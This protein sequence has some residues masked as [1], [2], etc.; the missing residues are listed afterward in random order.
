MQ[1]APSAPLSADA[2][3]F[4]RLVASPG[5]NA[6]Q[7]I[8]QAL[9]RLDAQLRSDLK[10]CRADAAPSADFQW[11]R[12][13]SVPMQGPR[14]LSFLAHDYWNCGGA[15]DDFSILGLV[16]DLSTGS[17][18]NWAR[19]LPASMVQ[20]TAID[21]AGDGTSIGVLSSRVFQDLY[22]K[23]ENSDPK[24]PLDPE[25]RDVLSD[26]GLKFT[27]WPDAEGDGIAI[28][29]QGLPHVVAACGA[30]AI[31]IPTT[32]LRRLGV[33]PALLDAIDTAHAQGWYSHKP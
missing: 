9:G 14:Y 7:R 24:N 18:V 29:T 25:C 32:T 10:D 19:L 16:Y 8:N 28:Q 15:H 17:P 22:L 6:A 4:P 23:A 31:V 12:T 13:I 5:D 1:L 3:A 27:I 20:G 11:S 21:T 33:Q 30:D 2:V 26:P